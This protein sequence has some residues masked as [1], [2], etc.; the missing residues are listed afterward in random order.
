MF[1]QAVRNEVGN[2]AGGRR[3][4]VRQDSNHIGWARTNLQLSVHTWRATT[5]AKA[6]D[7]VDHLVFK[8]E[9]V[10]SAMCVDLAG[11]EHIL[12]FGVEEFVIL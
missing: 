5:V 12:E 6:A 1:R 4:Q 8:S 2:L 7:A 11:R 10:P 9:S 3:I